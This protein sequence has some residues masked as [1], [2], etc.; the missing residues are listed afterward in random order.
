MRLSRAD[1]RLLGRRQTR[2]KHQHRNHR[3]YQN[4]DIQIPGV[5][6][7]VHA[8]PFFPFGHCL[9]PYCASQFRLLLDRQGGPLTSRDF[10]YSI[11]F[12]N[13]DIFDSVTPIA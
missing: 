13:Q 12:F 11:A 5:F 6:L 8:F 4:D 9:A 7:G 1:F 3:H 10:T 2:H